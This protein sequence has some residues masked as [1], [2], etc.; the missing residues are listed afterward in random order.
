MTTIEPGARHRRPDTAPDA[1]DALTMPIAV[2]TQRRVG[3]G[4]SPVPV[5]PS[6]PINQTLE[7]PRKRR[8][9]WPWI[10]LACFTALMVIEAVNP[11]PD[12]ISDP[13]PA[14]QAASAPAPTVV[15]A[16]LPAP[17]PVV[18]APAAPAAPPAAPGA[19]PPAAPGGFVAAPVDPTNPVDPSAPDSALARQGCQAFESGVAPVL[20]G[21]VASGDLTPALRVQMGL[22]PDVHDATG[23]S[24]SAPFVVAN[25]ALGDAGLGDPK[26]QP[27]DDALNTLSDTIMKANPSDD[28]TP[29]A[30][31]TGEV[32]SR[33]ERLAP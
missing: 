7:P 11:T 14:V 31:R 27:I 21:A 24:L 4:A 17:A 32:T 9:R 5:A 3:V 23:V 18:P 12:P 29:I 19:A 2:P 22:P 16:P 8:R 33:C 10:V 26:Y 13:A 20:Q 6:A 30:T 25:S 1:L 15:P 28:L